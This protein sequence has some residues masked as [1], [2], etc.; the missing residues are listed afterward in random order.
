MLHVVFHPYHEDWLLAS[1]YTIPDDFKNHDNYQKFEQL[2]VSFDRG[3]NWTKIFDYVH[4]Y[5][6]GNDKEIKNSLI[7]LNRIILIYNK[8]LSNEKRE[9]QCIYSDD[10]FKSHLIIADNISILQYE[11]PYLIYHNLRDS[12]S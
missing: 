4:L 10:F 11:Y 12:I 6:W 5:D 2:F 8:S 1:A 7:P 3:E 9:Y